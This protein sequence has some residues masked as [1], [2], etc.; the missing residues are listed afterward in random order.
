MHYIHTTIEREQL[1]ADHFDQPKYQ[2]A[3]VAEI[4]DRIDWTDRYRDVVSA[5]SL[6]PFVLV[7]V[8]DCG[9]I[10]VVRSAL[11]PMQI[12]AMV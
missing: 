2:Y 12:P 9:K 1:A 4:H 8:H 3:G 11:M 6:M 5:W 10:E 7:A